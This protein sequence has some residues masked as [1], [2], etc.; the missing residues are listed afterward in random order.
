MCNSVQV[1]A[2]GPWAG[3]KLTRAQKKSAFSLVYSPR[4]LRERES[5]AEGKRGGEATKGRAEMRE[6]ARAH[7][8]TQAREIQQVLHDEPPETAFIPTHLFS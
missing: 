7:Y 6:R 5:G 2:W 4:G 8:H 3:V 1:Y